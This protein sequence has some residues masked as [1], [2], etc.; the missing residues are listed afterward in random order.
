M[1]ER[2]SEYDRDKNDWYIEP[3][4]CVTALK[5]RIEFVGLSHDPCC[6]MGTIP[7]IMRGTGS[8]LVDRG[9]GYPVRDFLSDERIYDNIVTN[10]PYGIAQEII[11]HAL[12]RT[13]Y[14][15]AA[16]V[17]TKFLSSQKRHSLFMRRETEQVLMF[18]RRPSM[19]PGELLIE[20][21]EDIR[22]GG[23]IDYCWVVWNT[24]NEKG[25]KISWI[26]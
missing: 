20:H 3:E 8:D 9:F 14:K 6:G 11:L 7:K 23:S 22:G 15:V 17:Q 13:K 2:P 21:G 18:S 24:G 10:P 25:C 26:A 5:S 16:L 1:G 19:P 4:W 12:N